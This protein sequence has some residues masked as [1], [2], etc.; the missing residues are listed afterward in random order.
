MHVAYPCA[1]Y[2]KAQAVTPIHHVTSCVGGDA[3]TAHPAHSRSLSSQPVCAVIMCL[4]YHL[5]PYVACS[6]RF[7]CVP[8]LYL[9]APSIHN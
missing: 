5:L 2:H 3:V 8:T 6:L 1:V 9:C 4:T 7:I